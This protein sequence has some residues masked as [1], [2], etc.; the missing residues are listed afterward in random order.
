MVLIKVGLDVLEH[1]GVVRIIDAVLRERVVRETV[2]VLGHVYVSEAHDAIVLSA[3]APEATDVTG[4]LQNDKIEVVF[5]RSVM[6]T[7]R[8]GFL[9]FSCKLVFFLL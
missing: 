3:E 9:D 6:K 8:W 1:L 7:L 5:L 2:V 4:S